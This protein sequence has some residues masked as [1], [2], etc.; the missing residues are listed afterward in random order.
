M[1][2]LHRPGQGRTIAQFESDSGINVDYIEEIN[3]N[4]E[5][6]AKIQPLLTPGESGG[7][8]MITLSDWLAAKMYG[9]GYIYQL[10]NSKL[11]NVR[12]T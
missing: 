9:L 2:A 7:R 4:A 8:D 12:R 1:A 3:D 10:D 11:P 5:F 6:F